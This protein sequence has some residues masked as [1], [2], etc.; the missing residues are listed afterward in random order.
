[1]TGVE[2]PAATRWVMTYRGIPD[3]LPLALEHGPA[4]VARLREFQTRGLVLMAG[5]LTEPFDG[6]AM[7]IFATREAAEEFVAGDPFVT[8]GAVAEWSLRAWAEGLSSS[9]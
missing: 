9:S 6:G 8:S 3:F 4:H 2:P 7:A 5:P 1:M